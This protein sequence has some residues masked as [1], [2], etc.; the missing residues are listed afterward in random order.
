M[1]MVK[2]FTKVG[3]PHCDAA[4]RYFNQENIDYEQIDVYDVPGAGDEAM[5]LAG[6]ARKVPVIVRDNKVE[7]GFRGGY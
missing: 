3:C 2:I 7:V 1:A 5:K 6:G 4:L